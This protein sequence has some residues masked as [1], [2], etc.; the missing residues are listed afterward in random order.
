MRVG[1]EPKNGLGH[2]AAAKAGHWN[3]VC[4]QADEVKR[5]TVR[6]LRNARVP[7]LKAKRTKLARWEF[8]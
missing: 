4:R 3:G 8:P 7:V 5:L 2:G 6:K 1:T